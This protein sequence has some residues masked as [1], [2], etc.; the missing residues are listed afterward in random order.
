MSSFETVLTATLLAS[1]LNM[2][3]GPLA[4]D[5][6]VK[7]RDELLKQNIMIK[8]ATSKKKEITPVPEDAQ[9]QV[10]S[11][12]TGGVWEYLKLESEEIRKDF[13]AFRTSIAANPI[14]TLPPFGMGIRYLLKKDSPE[15]KARAPNL[16]ESPTE[17]RPR[18]KKFRVKRND[19]EKDK[20]NH[21]YIQEE[22]NKENLEDYWGY[23]FGGFEASRGHRQ[24]YGEPLAME[25]RPVFCERDPGKL[26]RIVVTFVF[27]EGEEEGA[28]WREISIEVPAEE[29]EW[30]RQAWRECIVHIREYDGFTVVIEVGEFERSELKAFK[31]AVDDL[32]ELLEL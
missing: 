18:A 3:L 7:Q 6:L 32:M 20:R 9:I 8:E 25:V 14:L 27:T 16:K 24:K 12:T 13:I 22:A 23:L 19:I 2:L 21:W 5:E 30:S 26:V 11:R 28:T 29:E 4:R 10:S 17:K 1:P 31:L 15:V